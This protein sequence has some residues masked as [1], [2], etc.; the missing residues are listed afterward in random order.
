MSSIADHAFGERLCRLLNLDA[1]R[2][3]WLALNVDSDGAVTVVTEVELTSDERERLLK[4]MAV[5]DVLLLERTAGGT[6]DPTDN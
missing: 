2:L 4:E 1:E 6:D 5:Y 3:T